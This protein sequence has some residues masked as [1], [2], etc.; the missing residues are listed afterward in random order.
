MSNGRVAGSKNK[1]LP[2]PLVF[3]GLEPRF[4]TKEAAAY[5]RRSPTTLEIWRCHGGGP[6]FIRSGGRILYALSDLLA[7]EETRNHTSE[8]A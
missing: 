2:A 4:T 6:R 1:P 5:L 7:F 3:P 8:A